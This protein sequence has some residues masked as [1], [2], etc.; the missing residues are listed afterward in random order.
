MRTLIILLAS[1]ALA[2]RRAAAAAEGRQLPE[3]LFAVRRFLQSDAIRRSRR[4]PQRARPV[5]IRLDAER[6]FLPGDAPALAV[7]FLNRDCLAD[8]R[9]APNSGADAATRRARPFAE[10]Q[11]WNGATPDVT[12][13]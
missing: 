7:Q 3:R 9:L 4:D 5:S 13:A 12:T 2:P 8:V 1:V 6:K 11:L 10:R